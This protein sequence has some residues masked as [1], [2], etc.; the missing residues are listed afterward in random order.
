M[1][2]LGYTLVKESEHQKTPTAKV[3]RMEERKKS[4]T[5]HVAE[6]RFTDSDKEKIVFDRMK[7]KDDRVVFYKYSGISN[8]TS[9]EP[10]FKHKKLKDVYFENL[11]DVHTTE[12][13][14]KSMTYEEAVTEKKPVEKIRKGEKVLEVSY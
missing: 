6:L 2:L 14:E 9:Y 5:E 12:R 1:G 8:T 11:K 10:K 4:Y 13:R 7:V 3:E